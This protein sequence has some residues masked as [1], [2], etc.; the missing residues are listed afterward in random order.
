MKNKTNMSPVA[1]EI[2]LTFHLKSRLK[3][4]E[5]FEFSQIL[6]LYLKNCITYVNIALV[7]RIELCSL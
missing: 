5:N 6:Q 1:F 4:S 3:I 7:K 2:L